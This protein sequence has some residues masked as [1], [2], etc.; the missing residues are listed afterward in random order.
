MFL[1]LKL[2]LHLNSVLMLNWIVWNVDVFDVKTVIVFNWKH[3]EMRLLN[4]RIIFF[5]LLRVSGI[6]TRTTHQSTTPYLSQT[7]WPRWASTQFLS[8]PIV[9]TL[10]PETFAYSLSSEAVVIRQSKRWKRLWEGHWHAH[11][12]GLPLGLSEVVGTVQ[13]QCRWRG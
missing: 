13:V 5:Y 6:S 4:L 1:T 11:T 7:I 12:R 2:Y 10:L 3:F 8:L 9:Q